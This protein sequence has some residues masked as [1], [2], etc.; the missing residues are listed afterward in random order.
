MQAALQRATARRPSPHRQRLGQLVPSDAAVSVLIRPRSLDPLWQN[1]WA[2]AEEAAREI[3]RAL[4]T[5]WEGIDDLAIYLRL[6]TEAELGLVVRYDASRL[7]AAWQKEL[8]RPAPSRPWLPPPQAWIAMQLHGHARHWLQLPEAPQP[9]D[10]PRWLAKPLGPIVGQDKLPQLLQSLGPDWAAWLEPPP[11]PTEL[12]AA[13]VAIAL[14][15]EEPRRRPAAQSLLQTAEFFFHSYRFTYNATHADQIDWFERRHGPTVIK[16]LSNPRGF[17]NGFAPA[18]AVTGD[19]NYLIVATSPQAIER[20][21]RRPQPGDATDAT[22]AVVQAA[23][24]R[25]YLLRHGDDLA[26]Q[27]A[28]FGTADA[29]THRRDLRNLALL[30]EWIDQLRL[31]FRRDRDTLRLLL[32]VKASAPLK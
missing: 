12:P 5:L 25:E 7:P 17:P 11:S 24:I 4:T 9:T 21:L 28:R 23:K 16:G 26:E 1:S 14:S 29:P 18:Y 3:G 19:C 31:E 13:A 32:R 8:A 2:Q 10:V 6:D 30:A 22:V 27:L 15:G 20:W